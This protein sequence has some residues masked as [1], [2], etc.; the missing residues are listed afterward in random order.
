M[1]FLESK[2]VKLYNNFAENLNRIQDLPNRRQLQGPDGSKTLRPIESLGAPC[3]P[4]ILLKASG[5]IVDELPSG[6]GLAT[7]MANLFV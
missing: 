5:F 6:S 2:L 1:Q 4:E 7:E 3:N